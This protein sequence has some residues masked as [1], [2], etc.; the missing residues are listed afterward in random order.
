M[1]ALNLVQEGKE[2]KSMNSAFGRPTLYTA[3]KDGAKRYIASVRW[4]WSLRY[5]RVHGL[6]GGRS[7]ALTSALNI[8][9]PCGNACKWQNGTIVSVLFIVQANLPRVLSCLMAKRA[10]STRCSLTVLLLCCLGN[11]FDSTAARIHNARAWRARG[12]CSRSGQNVVALV[13][14][15]RLIRAV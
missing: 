1:L 12:A 6:C 4:H 10:R 5:S 7:F 14:S 3:S 8:A 11:A 9:F 15:L 2:Q 13:R